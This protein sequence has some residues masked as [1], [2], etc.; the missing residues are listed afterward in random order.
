MRQPSSVFGAFPTVKDWLKSLGLSEYHK[1]FASN[2]SLTMKIIEEVGLSEKD[3]DELVI[4]DEFCR[5]MLLQSCKGGFTPELI[6]DVNGAR[7]FGDVVVYRV[8]AR[9]RTRRSVV[10]FRFSDFVKIQAKVRVSCND[11]PKLLSA[12]PSLP[13]KG[14]WETRMGVNRSKTFVSDR[15]KALGVW[16]KSVV[17][18][19]K[20]EHDQLSL[21]LVIL[22]LNI[23]HS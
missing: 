4:K 7:D 3:L 15:Q 10:Y 17:N 20:N 22:E 16:L 11:R 23:V 6:A 13:G 1:N 8:N 12:L 5:R 18:V 9:Y 21:L 2:P 19:V 14:I